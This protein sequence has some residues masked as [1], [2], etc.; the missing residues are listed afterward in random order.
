MSSGGYI[1]YHLR[2]N[3]AVERQLFIDLLTKIHASNSILNHTYV[4]FGGPFLED[5]KMLHNAFDFRKMISLEVDEN[6]HKR[7]SFNKPYACIDCWHKD[8]RMLIDEY[9]HI[10]DSNAIVWLDYA[11][12][13]DFSKQ[14]HEINDLLPKL[15]VNDVLKV[16]FNANPSVLQ[17]QTP[18]L[19][20][21]KVHKLRFVEF[22]E[23]CNSFFS[24]TL[25]SEDMM[26]KKSFSKAVHIVFNNLI[27]KTMEGSGLSLEPLT[28]FIYADSEH[29]MYTFTGVI[30]ENHNKKDFL[31]CTGITD[32]DMYIGNS[33]NPLE[34]SIPVLSLKEKNHF[35]QVLPL[36]KD[37]GNRA[38]IEAHDAL[39]FCFDEQC[40]N[41]QN[42][43]LSY[44]KFYRNVPFFSK[45][46][47]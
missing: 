44:S 8:S 29:Q 17:E 10:V 47:M 13:S 1:P 22:A 30:L 16:T 4:G 11:D 42:M 37:D 23:R 6:V 2:V 20:K 41:S 18:G 36:K 25:I 26:D 21:R 14:L 40:K 46:A 33:G 24:P 9:Q 34:I 28:S 31:S 39:G 7:Q 35:D 27:A 45:V 38:I 12:P 5:F 15:R 19:P 3:K 43:I 32:W